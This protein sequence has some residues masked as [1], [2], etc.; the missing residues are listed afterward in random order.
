MK[1]RAIRYLD[2]LRS[3]IGLTNVFDGMDSDCV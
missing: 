1:I 2:P 3:D